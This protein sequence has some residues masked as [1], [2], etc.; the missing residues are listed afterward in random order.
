MKFCVPLLLLIPIILARGQMLNPSI[1]KPG[2]PFCYFSQPT[3]VIGV[4][5]GTEG[6]L[7]TPEGYLYTGSGELMFFTGNPPSPLVQRVKTLE[8]GYL[9]I[10]QYAFEQD[11]MRY[12]V[13]AFAATLDGRPESPLMNF[14]RVR[15]L[16]STGQDRTAFFGAGC[17]YQNEV[18]T[19]WG[20][21]D[22][23]FARPEAASSPG[24]RTQS[25]VSFDREWTYELRDDCFLR[26][27]KIMY[28]FPVTPTLE[29]RITLKTG[30]N[31]PFL[32][33]PQQ[34]D[35]LPSTTAGIVMYTLRL[36]AG[37]ETVLDFKM[38]YDPLDPSSTEAGALRAVRFD[39]L[40]ARTVAAW[41]EIFARGIEITLP[42]GKVVDAFKANLIFD[43]IARNKENGSYI[44]K[45]NEFQYD[46]FWLRDASAIAGMYDL[47]GYHDLASQCLEFFPR[48]QTADGNF[49]SQGGQYDG[50]GQ[51]LVVY[52]RHYRMTRDAVF[53]GSVFPAVKKAVAWLSAARKRDPFHIMPQSTPGD[54]EDI[55][56]HVTG[57]NFIALGG[58]KNAIALAR[59]IGRAAEAALF[60]GEYNDYLGA[61]RNR[62]RT[63]TAK[64][65]GYIPPGL[66]TLGGQDWGNMESVSP[67]QILDPFDPMV[68][69]TL[70]A[71]RAKYQEGIM[72][73]GSGRWLHHYMTIPNCETELVRGEQQQVIEDLYA[74]LL[75]TASTHTGFEYCIRP[76]GTR[77]FGMNLAPHG[78]FAAKYRVLLRNMFVREDGKTLHLF[79]AVSPE[80]IK[81]GDSLSVRRAPTEFGPVSVSMRCTEQ[82]ATVNFAWSFHTHP[83]KVL[84]HIPWF[85]SVSSVQVDGAS[86]SPEN[87]SIP[88]PAGARSMYV[89]W[90]RVNDA[91][92]MSYQRSVNE[93]KQEYRRRYDEFLVNGVR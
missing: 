80:W 49:L 93:Y 53:A 17:R 92:P 66:D 14:I 64:T 24:A 7:V 54:N 51:T 25:G 35:V 33:G 39:D 5:D 57:H 20:F 19:D 60:E 45:V 74:L 83:A 69:A 55:S 9:P 85:M 61:L 16:N 67:E 23:R 2:E 76:W 22:N 1:D 42:E 43:L 31:T 68:T 4:M 86:V 71:T 44:Q 18:N 32:S 12:T 10:V 3:D 75:H 36:S 40:R 90:S 58:L 77:D 8:R 72:T 29:R 47:S 84:F 82:G 59:G 21:G 70:R 6:T 78:W 62:L 13:A 27:G 56:G 91:P 79:S 50:W 11:G 28:M 46:A 89:T 37:K 41:E 38:P 52:G 63:V 81:P 73:Y 15:A 65:G 34:M 26:G 48:W 87:G 88:V 30:D